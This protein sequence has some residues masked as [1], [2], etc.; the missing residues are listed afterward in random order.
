MYWK[1]N[2]VSAPVFSF[3]KVLFIPMAIALEFVGITGI[4][5]FKND[6]VAIGCDKLVTLNSN[7]T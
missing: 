3:N 2:N 5:A 6:R 4:Q 1:P 7:A